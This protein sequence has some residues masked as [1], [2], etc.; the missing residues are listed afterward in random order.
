MRGL[1]WLHLECARGDEFHLQFGLRVLV[2][3][4]AALGVPHEHEEFEG[5]HFELGERF[6][7][8]LPR[9]IAVLSAP[10]A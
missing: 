7:I 1:E 5:G 2:E 10:P 4:L 3:R 6:R 9:M 8:L